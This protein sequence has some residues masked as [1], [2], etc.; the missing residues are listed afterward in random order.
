MKETYVLTIPCTY[1]RG[2]WNRPRKETYERD[3]WKRTTYFLSYFAPMKEMYIWK[4]PTYSLSH[5]PM[6]ETHVL[7]MLWTRPTY[8]LSCF[9]PR[10]SNVHTP[11]K[12]TY[13]RD[14]WKRPMKE[15]YERDLWKRPMKEFPMQEIWKSSLCKNPTYPLSCFAPMKEM[16]TWKRPTYSLYYKRDQCTIKHASMKETYERDLLKRPMKETHVLSIL[17]T[18]PMYTPT[19]FSTTWVSFIGLFPYSSLRGTIITARTSANFYLEC[20]HRWYWHPRANSQKS[21]R[22]SIY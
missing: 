3:L 1:E 11:M 9:A 5:V 2:L 15:T 13:E 18:R 8:F 19:C 6:K 14:L 12:E 16:Y 21:A 7:S 10:R 22:N 4:R 20:L 17:W